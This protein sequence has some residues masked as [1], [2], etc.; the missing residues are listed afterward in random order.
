MLRW[1]TLEVARCEDPRGS[2]WGE[3]EWKKPWDSFCLCNGL[4]FGACCIIASGAWLV[5]LLKKMVY[6]AINLVATA[7]HPFSLGDDSLR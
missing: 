1:Q 3:A 6:V 4:Q 7:R 2:S 5:L